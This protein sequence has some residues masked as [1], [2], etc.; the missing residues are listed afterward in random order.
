METDPRLRALYRLAEQA[1][2][3]ALDRVRAAIVRRRS[4][5]ELDD[6]DHSAF[7]GLPQEEPSA[8]WRP[9][10]RP[11]VPAPRSAVPRR[12]R[13]QGERGY[14]IVGTERHGA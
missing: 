3:E 4:E 6:A 14:R 12:E 7:R 10:D 1:E 13:R 5:L 11:F 2:G 9:G 8:A